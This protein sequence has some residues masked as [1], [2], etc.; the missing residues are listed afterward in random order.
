MRADQKRPVSVSV[1][2]ALVLAV[3]SLAA[4]LAGPAAIGFSDILDVLRGQG[5]EVTRTILVELRLPRVLLG[6]LV[7]GTLGAAGAVLQA[8]F[9]NPLAEPGVI[10][11]SSS[12]ALG[13]VLVLYLGA[14]G[15]TS[16]LLPLSAMGM[17]IAAMGLLLAVVMSNASMLTLILAG[18]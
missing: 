15:F 16:V 13:A 6:V 1:A 14:A 8:M 5:G 4:L 17:A 18:V 7:G 10:G 3:V 11:V 9:R 2:L 12:A